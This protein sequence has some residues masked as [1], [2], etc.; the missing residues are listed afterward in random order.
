[1]IRQ[2]T[3]A[4][5]VP[6]AQPHIAGTRAPGSGRRFYIRCFNEDTYEPVYTRSEFNAMV[7]SEGQ[8]LNWA[9]KLPNFRFARVL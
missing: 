9:A 3:A 6:T 5:R 2:H 7:M 4:R 8:A 1:M